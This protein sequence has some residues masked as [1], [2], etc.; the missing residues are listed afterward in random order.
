MAPERES[1]C[2]SFEGFEKKLVYTCIKNFINFRKKNCTDTR[3]TE[4]VD[5][6]PLRYASVISHTC[7]AFVLFVSLKC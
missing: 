3:T 5:N 1:V 2:R 4:Q 6:T 7:I